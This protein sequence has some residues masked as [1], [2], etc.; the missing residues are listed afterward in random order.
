MSVYISIKQIR[1]LTNNSYIWFVFSKISNGSFRIW[2]Q[3]CQWLYRICIFFR[4]FWITCAN[5]SKKKMKK[6]ENKLWLSLLNLSSIDWMAGWCVWV[7]RMTGKLERNPLHK[8]LFNLTISTQTYTRLNAINVMVNYRR[9]LPI[10]I[11]IKWCVLLLYFIWLESIFW[12][13][14]V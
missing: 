14:S 8:R 4:C 11:P 12:I 9:I 6:I 3:N 10:C 5:L 13:I 2:V 1:S 7:L